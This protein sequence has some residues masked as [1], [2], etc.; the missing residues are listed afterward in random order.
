VGPNLKIKRADLG[1]FGEGGVEEAEAET[2]LQVSDG[3]NE[4][5]IPLSHQVI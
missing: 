3:I 2:V 1:S 5:G 4:C